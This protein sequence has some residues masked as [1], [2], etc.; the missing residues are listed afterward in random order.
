MYKLVAPE[1]KE[2]VDDQLR[3]EFRQPTKEFA[4][5]FRD[6]NHPRTR[7]TNTAYPLFKTHMGRHC[8]GHGAVQMCC[9]PMCEGRVSEVARYGPGVSLYFKWLKWL[10]FTFFFLSLV[11][12]LPI[13]IN[14]RTGQESSGIGLHATTVGNLADPFYTLASFGDDEGVVQANITILR[15]FASE[16]VVLP[17]TCGGTTA[18]TM[19]RT[20]LGKIYSLLDVLSIVIF[21]VSLQWLRQFEKIEDQ[22]IV[23]R[24]LSIEEY[25]V[26][27]VGVPDD[28]DEET[29]QTFFEEL[30]G[31]YVA[32]VAL[33]KS[34]AALIGLY[35]T[36]GKVLNRL[37]KAASRSHLLY[38]D[39]KDLGG[40]VSVCMGEV[41]VDKS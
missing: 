28:A 38:R 40:K 19:K 20:E 22:N 39:H 17:Y 30:V 15:N 37:W 24:H 8:F 10:F 14:M 13:W 3:L 32:E 18:C 35:V 33:A 21:L 6:L 36:R 27:V 34:D 4:R 26:H 29:L 31:E 5:L 12:I 23:K 7:D 11:S 9:D 41:V 1:S 2:K 25:T 16:D